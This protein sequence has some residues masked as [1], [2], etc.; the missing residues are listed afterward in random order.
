[1]IDLLY[2]GNLGCDDIPTLSDTVAHLFQLEQRLVE[3][4][5]GLPGDLS[6]LNSTAMP[7]L[8]EETYWLGRYRVILTLRYHN[9]CI[10]LHRVIVVKFLDACGDTDRDEHEMVSL[11]QIGSNSVRICLQSAMEI[12]SIVHFVVH[13][14]D[15]RRE[16]LGAWWFSLYYSTLPS[17]ICDKKNTHNWQLSTQPS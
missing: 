12:I 15:S 8:D 3:W 10:L 5:R 16:C 9:L 7:S 17:L 6:L 1:M 4:K 14:T 2:G 13:S 11:Q